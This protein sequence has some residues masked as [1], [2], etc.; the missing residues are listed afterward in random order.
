MQDKNDCREEHQ[1]EASESSLF[2]ADIVDKKQ[3]TTTCS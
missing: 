1:V 3:E 2:L